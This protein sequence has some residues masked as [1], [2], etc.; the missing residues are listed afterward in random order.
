MGQ[1]GL[2]Y[3]SP[4][5]YTAKADG[6]CELLLL[7]NQA[8]N[9]LLYRYTHVQGQMVKLDVIGRAARVRGWPN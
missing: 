1:H 7:D 9:R 3:D 6:P 8:L 4:H 2:L 5:V